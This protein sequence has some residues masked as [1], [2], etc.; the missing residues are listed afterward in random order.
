[1]ILSS[2]AEKRGHAS[3]RHSLNYRHPVERTNM[4]EVEIGFML[5][6]CLSRRTSDRETMR[7]ERLRLGRII[8]ARGT[9][10]WAGRSLPKTREPNRKPY[11]P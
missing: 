4:A 2:V 8:R 5:G 11:I 6:R 10:Q 9:R 7:R 1:M 3:L